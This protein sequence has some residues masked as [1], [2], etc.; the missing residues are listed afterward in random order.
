[1]SWQGKQV[2]IIGFGIEG[3][4]ALD[5][6][7]K[8]GAKVTVCDKIDEAALGDRYTRSREKVEAWQLGA[9]YLHKLKEVDAVF[10]SPGTPF[11]SV[12][13]QEALKSGVQ[14]TSGTKEFFQNCPARIVGVTGTKGKGTT[15]TLIYEMLKAAGQRAYLVGNI[16]KPA[17]S[18]LP[19]LTKEDIV[20]F[21]LS[22]FQ[23]QDLDSSPSIAVV[24]GVTVDHQD[25]HA[26]VEEYEES[27]SA[28]VRF[29][30][31]EDVTITNIDYPA[32]ERIAAE[33]KGRLVPVSTAR[34]LE[35]G[36]YVADGNIMQNI[37]G[38]PISI[39]ALN[40]IG[41]RGAFNAENVV[42]AVAAG[43]V[44]GIEEE[45]IAAVLRI[46]TGLPHRLE[47]VRDVRGVMYWDNSYATTPETTVAAIQSFK[48]PIVL[49]LGGY[50]KGFNYRALA[51]GVVASSVKAIVGIG[52][53]APQM[54]EA[55]QVAA[56]KAGKSAPQ[57]IEGG[58]TMSSMISAANSVAVSEDVVLLSPAAASFDKFKNVTDRGEQFKKVVES[59]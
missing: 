12:E 11:Y 47:F 42:A 45:T 21:E 8:N 54:Y 51:D 36:V 48:E 17:L 50:E 33:T 16:G 2:A 38:S 31:E 22:S 55:V 7:I 25:H 40:E 39:V 58:E 49:L 43:S 52:K 10:R 27:K 5:Y 13:I 4:A 41:L 19:E 6:L 56:S 57:Y 44:L 15:A 30:K 59:L 3:E 9:D 46:F 23:L 1:M 29:Q 34:Q 24:L 53:N 26:S 32:S 20:V 37:G 18:V 28:I 14:I 35:Y